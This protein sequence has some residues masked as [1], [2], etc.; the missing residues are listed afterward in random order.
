[1]VFN[2]YVDILNEGEAFFIDEGN[3]YE[4]MMEEDKPGEQAR[5]PANALSSSDSTAAAGEPQSQEDKDP[6]VGM[7]AKAKEGA[8]SVLRF[9]TNQAQQ[10]GKFSSEQIGKVR[11]RISELT[12]KTSEMP[13]T[14]DENNDEPIEV[15]DGGAE[16]PP[17]LNRA[18][19]NDPQKAEQELTRYKT[20]TEAYNE[21]MAKKTGKKRFVKGVG[22]LLFAKWCLREVKKVGADVEV[23]L[24]EGKF[25]I[26]VG[27]R[28]AQQG[29][30]GNG[31]F[32]SLAMVLKNV[33]LAI[34]VLIG[35]IFK[36]LKIYLGAI[37]KIFASIFST[38]GAAGKTLV[39]GQVPSSN[40]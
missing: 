11:A 10:F 29:S 30:N 19:L 27:T 24:S 12:K 33:F 3:L 23:N 20:A 32:G 35:G 25:A 1:M 40:K 6:K 37:G 13:N 31:F 34:L 15:T 18:A 5:V 4:L 17:K 2:E 39:T 38:V 26:G 9:F 8:K 22:K 21:K 28:A 7:G 36:V 16:D 14:I